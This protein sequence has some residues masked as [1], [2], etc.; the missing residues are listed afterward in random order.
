MTSRLNGHATAPPGS[1]H[2]EPAERLPHA[3]EPLL[4]ELS[5]A[6]REGQHLPA[7]D[8]PASGLPDAGLLRDGLPLP[9][10]SEPEV[11]RHFTRL[12][13]L[14]Y[15]VDTGFYPLGSCTMKYNPKIDDEMAA[16]SG[17]A[18]LHPYQ[19]AETVQG[20]LRLMWE[21]ERALAAITGFAAVTLQPAAGAHGE[22]TGMLMI[23]AHHLA[24][25]DTR[26][27]RVLVPDSAHGTNPATAAMCG[28]EAVTVPS[29][30][31][32]NVDLTALR[33]L[34]GPDVAALMIT[35]PSTLGLFDEHMLEVTAAVHETGAL[36]YGD[37]ANLNALLGIARPA[38]LGLDV[39]HINLHKTFA[40]PHGGG[41]P[42][43][44]PVAVRAD[45]EPYLPL[46]VVR[47]RPD[48]TYDLDY[49]RPHSIGQ[50]RAF[51][52]HFGVLV[53]A[54]TYIRLLGGDGLRRV[55]EAA[56]L[57]A[58]YLRAV[59]REWYDVPYDRPCMHEVLLSGRRQ[60][61]QGARTLDVA[62]RLI[63]YGFHPPTI[64]FPLVV[65]EALMIEPTETEAKP[66]LDAFIA[67]MAAIAVEAARA[68]AVLHAAPHDTPVGRLDEASAA[69]QPVLRWR[70][71]DAPALAGTAGASA[72][73]TAKA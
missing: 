36:V 31:R 15:A 63:D 54:Y 1:E 29:D 33:G 16:L 23:R 46:P 8:V 10:L 73:G 47:R 48:E 24:R 64:Y 14:N 57:H 49:I 27:R 11:V 18:G 68:P 26:R 37:G 39:L 7:P 44:G 56:V 52:T 71:A 70:R 66:T 43:A 6:G 72:V 58:N 21:L 61:A 55:S 12:S 50:V 9:E 51:G 62:K 22:L 38:D 35:V 32:G 20:A 19:P 69:R 25:G 2:R 17:F 5:V 28:Y 60:K 65:D 67:A 40:Q 41:G 59:L 3:P 13:Q 42:G 45:L 34:L 53:R 30:A 4:S